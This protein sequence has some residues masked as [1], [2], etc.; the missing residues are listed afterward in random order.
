MIMW[1]Y[2]LCRVIQEQYRFCYEAAL[3]YLGSFDHY[4]S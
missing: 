1:I 4:T 2:L 3:D